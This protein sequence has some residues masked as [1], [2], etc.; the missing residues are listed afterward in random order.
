MK[1]II[2]HILWRL[3]YYYDLMKFQKHQ[4]YI[5]NIDSEISLDV[6][7]RISKLDTKRILLF[8]TYKKNINHRYLKY[9][10][11]KIKLAHII[12]LNNCETNEYGV[13]FSDE[14][15]TWVNRPNFGRDIGAYKVGLSC[16]L[17]AKNLKL[18]D[19]TFLND[20]IFLMND[21]IFQFFDTDF[22]A[23]ILGHSFSNSPTPHIRSYLFRVKLPLIQPIWDYLNKLPLTRSRYAAIMHGEL[24]L[25]QNV[26]LKYDIKLWKLIPSSKK[27]NFDELKYAID[28]FKEYPVLLR[29]IN[30]KTSRGVFNQIAQSIKTRDSLLDPYQLELSSSKFVPDVLKREVLDKNLASEAKL[31]RV[32]LS[33]QLPIEV[34]AKVLAEIFLPKYNQTFIYKVKSKI[35]EI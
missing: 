24:G 1:K 22:D 8:A 29:S 34:Q 9:I 13:E 10:F 27:E 28:V 21:E 26:L 23:D 17:N 15:L 30:E 4:A 14:K 19:V 35:G 31:N 32:V 33:S 7:R 2:K 3:Y 16:I 5:N 25:S 6:S 11:D 20:S 18:E 12:V